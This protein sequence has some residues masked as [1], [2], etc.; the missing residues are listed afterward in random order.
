MQQAPKKDNIM[1]RRKIL[2]LAVKDSKIIKTALS[3]KDPP[4]ELKKAK[5][6]TTAYKNYLKMMKE[7]VEQERPWTDNPQSQVHML[8]TS[9]DASRSRQAPCNHRNIAR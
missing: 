2:D 6:L 9:H 1:R 4:K 5:H 3:S 7:E 8:L